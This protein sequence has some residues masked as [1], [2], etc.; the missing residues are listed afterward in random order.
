MD[1]AC[2]LLGLCL[3]LLTYWVTRSASDLQIDF[4]VQPQT[5]LI[6]WKL[7]YYLDSW[8][9]VDTTPR[10]VLFAL[11]V[12]SGAG[13]WL[14][15]SLSCWVLCG[16]HCLSGSNYSSQLSDTHYRLKFCQSCLQCRTT[17]R[18]VHCIAWYYVVHFYSFCRYVPIC[19]LFWIKTQGW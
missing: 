6:S 14:V 16:A 19:M 1:S 9:N 3:T 17:Y 13:C 10:P 7:I 15:R 2:Y 5:S 12:Y 8:L 11:C 18:F 4:L